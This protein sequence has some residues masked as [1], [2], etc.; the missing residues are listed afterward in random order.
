MK[1]IIKL[2]F[3]D[4]IRGRNVVNFSF[5]KFEAVGD[6]GQDKDLFRITGILHYNNGGDD[7]VDLMF[8]INDIENID[9]LTACDILQKRAVWEW[10]KIK[11]I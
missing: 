2:D 4:F 1:K 6:L 3:E 7:A 11:N 8:K 10:F 9:K 5:G